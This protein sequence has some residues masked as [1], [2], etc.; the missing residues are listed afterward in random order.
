MQSQL[1]LHQ[2]VHLEIERVTHSA[3]SSFIGKREAYD[4]DLAQIEEEKDY[5]DDLQENQYMDKMVGGQSR[6]QRKVSW[7][8]NQYA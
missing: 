3:K 5:V 6:N 2:R 4:H 8:A 1:D 7:G